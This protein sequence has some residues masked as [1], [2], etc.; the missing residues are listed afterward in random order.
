MGGCGLGVRLM[1]PP[2]P[3]AQTRSGHTRGG[4]GGEPV[5]SVGEG[6]SGWLRAWRPAD[7][8][9]GS[10]RPNTIG[11]HE[12]WGRWGASSECRGRGEWVVAGFASG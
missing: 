4:V 12:G 11:S 7:A 2:A 10:W 1:A 3:A 9:T 6:V 5:V 8:T